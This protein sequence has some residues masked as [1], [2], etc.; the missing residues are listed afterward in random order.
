[1]KAIDVHWGGDPAAR[2]VNLVLGAWLFASAFIWAHTRAQL[3]NTWILG[4]V[5]VICALIALRV[6]AARYVN[7][8]L[9]VWLFISAFALPRIHQGTVWNNALVAVVIFFVS[10]V[11]QHEPAERGLPPQQTRTA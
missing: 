2:V 6:S 4:V 8:V 1:V 5:M 9:S 11:S 3:T 10:L 7:T